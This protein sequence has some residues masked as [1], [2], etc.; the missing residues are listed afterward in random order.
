MVRKLFLGVL[1]VSW[2]RDTWQRVIGCDDAN[3]RRGATGLAG[4]CLRDV[5]D[6]EAQHVASSDSLELLTQTCGTNGNVTRVSDVAEKTRAN[7]TENLGVCVN[8]NLED[9]VSGVIGV[10]YDRATDSS[11]TGDPSTSKVFWDGKLVI[12]VLV[13]NIVSANRIY[14]FRCEMVLLKCVLEKYLLH[15][16]TLEIGTATEE[17]ANI[18][19]LFTTLHGASTRDCRRASLAPEIPQIDERVHTVDLFSIIVVLLHSMHSLH[20]GFSGSWLI[21][22]PG[23]NGRLVEVFTRILVEDWLIC[24]PGPG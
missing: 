20:L 10:G 2:L 12:T 3:G 4:N 15:G 22:S 6:E 19:V 5:L 17:V 21:C 18:V 11:F 16:V 1:G 23:F 7:M 8:V 24:S 13:Y 9:T 14:V